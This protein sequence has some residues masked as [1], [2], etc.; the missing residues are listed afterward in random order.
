RQILRGIGVVPFDFAPPLV[1]MVEP[2]VA[3]D[4]VH[5]G[6]EASAG[7]IGRP[8]LEDAAVVAIEQRGERLD[9]AGAH[10]RHE[11]IVS[12][13]GWIP[14]DGKR[15]SSRHQHRKRH[16]PGHEFPS[17]PE[18]GLPRKGYRDRAAAYCSERRVTMGSTRVARRAGK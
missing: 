7:A 16:R 10:L 8:V 3:R 17:W 18:T 2:D 4:E 1:Q 9:L 13:A 11:E 5:P 14:S 6:G 15:G 12:V